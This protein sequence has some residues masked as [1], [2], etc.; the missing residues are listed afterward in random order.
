MSLRVILCRYLRM[1]GNSV[2]GGKIALRGMH[3]LPQVAEIFT[4][5]SVIRALKASTFPDEPALTGE[6]DLSLNSLA[7]WHKDIIEEMLLGT[8]I[9]AEDDFKVYKI[10][11]YLQDQRADSREVFKVK[12]GSHRHPDGSR[13]PKREV[14]VRAGDAIVFDV[15]L[16][17][18]GQQ[19]T[20]TE[21]AMHRAMFGLGFCTR[22]SPEDLFT[23][24]RQRG[25]FVKQIDRLG[26]FATFGPQRPCTFAYENAGRW[27]HGHPPTPLDPEVGEAL[28]QNNVLVLQR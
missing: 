12:A 17:H 15:R 19:P 18:A 25:R 24:A 1:K 2:H 11:F 22:R 5:D 10:A 3:A 8:G 16:D 9:Y 28:R 13:L 27:R 7:G 23:A 6:C 4:Q 21:R 14:A 20:L 26:I